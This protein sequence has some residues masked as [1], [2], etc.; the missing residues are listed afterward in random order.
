MLPQFQITVNITA[1]LLAFITAVYDDDMEPVLRAVQLLWVNLIMDTF[2]ALA[3]ATDPPTEKILDRLPQ[4]KKAPLITTNVS[5]LMRSTWASH[6]D[7]CSQMWKMIIG[8]AIY[9]LTI[10]L[11]LYFAGPEILG[12]DRNNEAQM[13]DLDT[14]IFNTFVWMQ[15]FNQFNNRR[16]DNKFNIFEGI[17]RNQFF[18]AINCLM[19]GL[20]V[21]IIFVGSRAFE[22]SGG[23]IN[24]EQW[25][26]S[27]VAAILCLPWAVV[28]RLV[29]D[30]L[31]GKVASFVGHPVVIVYRMLSRFVFSPI[32]RFFSRLFK[33]NKKQEDSEDDDTVDRES[34]E[35]QEEQEKENTRYD[36]EQP[37]PVLMDNAPAIVVSETPRFEVTDPEH[38][39]SK[40]N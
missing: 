16:L 13:L 39:T 27:I 4:G 5:S 14:I 12:Y 22:I 28:V 9:Q 11:V 33:R 18:I 31:F 24:G 10:T 25:A 20:Q 7:S 3:L 8:Q 36:E 15:I 34:V 2:A 40:A 35:R 29:P 17:H 32:S 30:E 19:V 1:V 37:N 23:G 26:I 21:G 6:A 38:S